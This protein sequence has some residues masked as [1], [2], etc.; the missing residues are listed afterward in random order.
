MVQLFFKVLEGG[1]LPDG[2]KQ[3][4]LT[5]LPPLAGK[6]V[7]LTLEEK[8][9]TSSHKQRRYYFGVIVPAFQQYFAGLGQN[10]DKDNLHD[11]MMR[12]IGGFNNPFVNPFT[13]EPDEGRKSYNDLTRAQAEGFHTICRKWLAEKGV[14]CPEPNEVDYGTI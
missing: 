11:S 10:Y 14:D 9:D 5:L 3:N 7:Y 8:R 2:I 4:L 13:G 1:K 12:N 6:E